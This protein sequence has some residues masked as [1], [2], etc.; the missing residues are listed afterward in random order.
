MIVD[1]WWQTETGGVVIAPSPAETKANIVP[2]IA[3]RPM[4]TYILHLCKDQLIY[5][6]LDSFALLIHWSLKVRT[7]SSIVGQ[8]KGGKEQSR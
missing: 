6:M 5:T 3:M 2:A 4:Y 1:T 7:E 8:G